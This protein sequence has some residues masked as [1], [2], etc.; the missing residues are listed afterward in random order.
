MIDV[1]NFK[2]L[3]R[4]IQLQVLNILNN[5]FGFEKAFVAVDSQNN[6]HTSSSYDSLR[7]T[8]P[9]RI[10][11]D[12]YECDDFPRDIELY[13]NVVAAGHKQWIEDDQFADRFINEDED[14]WKHLKIMMNKISDARLNAYNE[15]ILDKI[16]EDPTWKRAKKN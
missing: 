6:L 12:A 11:S 9:D 3:P 16:M 13:K 10:I 2:S 15:I 8:D 7:A 4:N 14:T 1:N 5:I